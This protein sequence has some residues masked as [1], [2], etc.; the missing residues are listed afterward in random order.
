M[1]QHSMLLRLITF[2]LVPMF[3]MG[4]VGQDASIP[5]EPSTPYPSFENL[6]I[7]WPLQGDDNLNSVV[8]VRY[9]KLGSQDWERGL[10]LIRVPAGSNCGFNWNNRHSGSIFGLLADT[11]YEI[12]LDFS[13]PDGG[14]AIKKLSARTRLWR[15]SPT[16]GKAVATEDFV[17]ELGALKAGSVLDLDN[18]SFPGFTVRN[19]GTQES[20][21]IIRAREKHQAT[22]QGD[23]RIDGQ[24]YVRIIGLQVEGMIKFNDSAHVSIENCVITTQRD[25]IVAYGKKV[26]S[27]VVTDNVIRGPCRWEESSLGNK[28]DNRGEGIVLTGPGH[29]IAHNYV[30]GFRD[31]I[32]L[33]EDEGANDQHS[34][35]IYRNDIYRCCDDGIEA[36]FAMGNVRV[37]ENRLTD[38]FMGISS[39]PSLGG[40]T[41]F[42][43]NQIYNALYQGFKLQRAS[44]G[45]IGLHN[46]IIKSGDAFN[47]ITQDVWSRAWFCNNLFIGGPGHSI[48]GYDSGA[49]RLLNLPS[50][51]ANCV[52]EK[53]GFG[54]IGTGQLKSIVGD[55]RCLDLSEFAQELGIQVDMSIFA[56]EI[57]LP[58]PFQI[59]DAVNPKLKQSSA[60]IDQGKRVPN[61]NDNHV[62]AA[63]DLGAI[64]LGTE[65]PKFGPR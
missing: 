22:I 18:D 48:N 44:V 7:E 46:T 37:Y 29:V 9:R 62:G 35:D 2:I 4:A 33:V 31:G 49:G 20:P 39:Q 32:S 15:A 60:A 42:V 25:G 63:P 10:N 6:S 14:R 41:Y 43:R 21:I 3:S 24:S 45:D 52:F 34:I 11:S 27:I 54:S 61:I 16:D 53:N 26:S 17:S 38:C 1:R 19:S 59:H 64:E 40:P 51:D 36:D 65:S 47:V 58:N 56:N 13:D 12:E 55:Q 30:E 28:G 23:I 5:G 8:T 50:V 57:E